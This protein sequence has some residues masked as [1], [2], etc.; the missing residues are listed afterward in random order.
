MPLPPSGTITF[1]FTDI[2]GSTAR[3][4]AHGSTMGTAVASHDE[5]MRAIF[6]Q[7]EGY[8]F[9]TVGD[10]FCVAF[11]TAPAALTAAV[12]AQRALAA[13][14]HSSVNGL[15]V[16]MGLHTGHADER[17]GDYFGPTVN[18]V[19]RLMSVG[20]G[21]QILLSAA[22]R[23]LVESELPQGASIQDLGS[24]RLKDLTNPEQVWQLTIPGAAET[25]P[26][27]KSVDALPNNLPIHHTSFRGR[28][29]DLDDVKKLL[30][31]HHLV[32]L[33]GPGGIGKTRLALQAAAEV[34]DDFPDGVW[35]ADLG[36]ISDPELVP[37]VIAKVL[38]VVPG[39]E[40]TVS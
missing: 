15:G 25:F 34:L 4:E 18:R 3:W 1:L 30:R 22:T 21:G 31:E 40:H 2:E 27:L 33:F 38:G 16:R 35:L 37:S 19:A 12:E 17:D 14:D 26:P 29:R 23:A 28:E 32:T 24:H 5:A 13:M 36:A 7:H 9:K 20:H 39:E 10:A 8:V 6:E 11:A